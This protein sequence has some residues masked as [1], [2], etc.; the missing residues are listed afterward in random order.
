MERLLRLALGSLVQRGTLRVTTAR[1]KTFA[2]GDGNGPTV[3]IRFATLASELG[4][5]LDPAFP[6]LPCP[7]AC[8]FPLAFPSGR[9][10]RSHPRV[11]SRG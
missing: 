9:A 1:G 7:R 8:A 10:K 3:A 2:V 6:Q 5:L 11:A 4:I